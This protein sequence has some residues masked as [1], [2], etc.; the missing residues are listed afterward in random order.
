MGIN[1]VNRMI[2]KKFHIREVDNLPYG[3]GRRYTRNNLA[4][5]YH[6]LGYKTGAEIGVRRGRYSRILCKENPNLTLYCVDPWSG[7][8]NKYTDEKQENIY[9]DAL[10][11]LEGLP[12]VIIRKSSIDALSDIADGSLDFIFIDGNHTYDYVAPDIIYWS[13]KVRSGGIV[14]VHDYYNFG[15]SGVVPAVNGYVLSHHIDPWYVT[16]ELEPTAFWVKP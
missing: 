3:S 2:R 14:S 12:V 15:M 4:E 10:K 5:L 16:K 6:D 9:Q 7:Y 1:D 13:K 8:S 11:N